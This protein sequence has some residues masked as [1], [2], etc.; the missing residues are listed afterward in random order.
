[1]SFLD[2]KRSDSAASALNKSSDAK[3]FSS[4]KTSSPFFT[5]VIQPKLSINEP[6]D[7][8]EQEADA[9]AEQVMRAPQ[10]RTGGDF[11]FQPVSASISSVQRK[12][13]HCEDEE[14]ENK[15]QMKDN[16]SDAGGTTAPATVKD[17]LGSNGQ[18]MDADTKN[19]M[20]SRFGE[21]FGDVQIHNDTR[22]SQSS[23]DINALAYTHS[24]HIVFANGQYQ[25]G[26]DAGKKLL[27]HELTHVVQQ[28]SGGGMV[29][30]KI[31]RQAAPPGRKESVTGTDGKK[32]EIRRDYSVL[33]PEGSTY[34]RPT[35]KFDADTTNI[36]FEVEWCK[37]TRG[38]IKIGTNLPG[39]AIDLLQ[40]IAKSLINGGGGQEVINEVKQTDLTPFLNVQVA[41][42][43]KWDIGVQTNVSVNTSSGDVTGGGGSISISTDKI[44]LSVSAQGGKD[45]FTIGA[46]VKI[47]L[48]GSGVEHFDCKKEKIPAQIRAV[49]TC[50]QV[51]PEHVE[52][53]TTTKTDTDQKIVYVYFEYAKTLV[54]ADRTKRELDTLKQL[55]L[56]NYSAKQVVG[57]TSP[58]GPR[59]AGKSGDFE[60]ND[61]L[62]RKRASTARDIVTKLCSDL[63]KIR[64]EL[65]CPTPTI[66]TEQLSELYT[67]T[68]EGKNG[69]E[70]VE[71][72]ELIG[73]AEPQFREST[74][75]QRFMND[76]KF[77][78]ALDKA[79]T[80]RQ[81]E[82][83][84]Y[85]L[86]RRSK[87]ILEKT[88]TTQ[89]TKDVTVPEK[90][91]DVECKS[92][93]GYDNI[94][95]NWDVNDKLFRNLMIK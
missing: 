50:E 92:V 82:Q 22:A 46:N 3:S 89:E 57:F 87:I 45:G 94:K 47:P 70:E 73:K 75:E 59:A 79:K 33:T 69:T 48:G 18:S 58:E 76:P 16:S 81:K 51:T 56:D 41:K 27:A 24:N 44:S 6:G 42:S 54:N 4:K 74:E 10:S 60:G 35:A 43:G 11:F 61:E 91:D 64:P 20:E 95:L 34:A 62:S 72:D 53:K 23:R 39:Q 2:T 7:R 86:L 77:K 71:G 15:V 67:A 25:P 8:Y 37:D 83:L 36:W 19:F 14:K 12:C 90:R 29:F 80:P 78:E 17:A 63:R 5:P 68:K 38:N 32:Y 88:T 40:R 55:I 1:M 30:P 49:D 93:P 84:I 65:D 52:P 28:R 13:Q 26:T 85:P 31:M 66:D 21:D 9:V